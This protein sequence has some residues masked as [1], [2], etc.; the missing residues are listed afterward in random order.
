MKKFG[1]PNLIRGLDIGTSSIKLVQLS[2]SSNNLQLDNFEVVKVAGTPEDFRNALASLAKKAIGKDVNISVS[3]PSVVVRYI[4][5]PKMTAS[6]L[7]SSMKFEAEKYIP[8]GVKDVILDCQPLGDARKGKVKVLLAAAKRALIDERIE[9]VE[10]AGFSVALIDCDSFALTNAFLHSFPDTNEDESI[11]LLNI[12]ERKTAIN[13]VKGKAPCFTRELQI[14]GY[15]FIKS[16]SESMGIDEK[17]ASELRSDPTGRYAEI[18]EAVKPIIAQ[19]V[20]EVKLSLN[21]YENQ[22]GASVTKI[23]LSGGLANFQGIEEIFTESVGV[24]S[25]LWDPLRHIKL[26]EDVSEEALKE[27]KHRLPVAVGLALRG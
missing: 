3:G 17:Q 24:K 10:S 23:A 15:D 8:F 14:G 13:I 19:I 18:M 7:K 4:E 5:L 26:S 22:A 16:M 25:E 1:N 12:G 6:E 21:Y 2:G 11:A 9:L 20:E 27:V